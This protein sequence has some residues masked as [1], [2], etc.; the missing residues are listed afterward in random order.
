VLSSVCWLLNEAC[1]LGGPINVA[2][3]L[4]VGALTA[5]EKNRT[6]TAPQADRTGA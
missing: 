5:I 4:D 2:G 1:A 3:K 6:A